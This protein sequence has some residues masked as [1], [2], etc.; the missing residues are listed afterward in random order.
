MSESSNE[1]IISVDN[2]HK[3]YIMGREA[4]E[5]L[6]GVS[7]DVDRGE[8]VCL[9]GPSG[10]GKTTLLNIL[11]GLDSPSRGHVIVDGENVVALN[12]E[13]LAR[14]R[15]RKMGFVFQAYNL[16]GNFT[17]EENVE[18]PMVLAG[19]KNGTRKKRAKELMQ[20]VGLADRAHH[21]PSELSG[22]QQ[23]RVAI[24]RA[25]ANDPAILVGDEMTGD[26]DSATGFEIM[27]LV[28]KLNKEHGTTVVYVTHDPR[29]SKYAHRVIQL[30][31]GKISAENGNGHDSPVLAVKPGD[32]V[33]DDDGKLIV[34]RGKH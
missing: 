26:L 34:D 33:I 4:V 17:A 28:E 15:L 32:L 22:G 3:S 10:S 16:L 12:E 18:A 23:Q 6:R 21:Y 2:I 25:M 5:A 1:P 8:I 9:M 13:A 11:G 7:L 24:A 30:R 29:M 14:M 27:S 20:L 19:V 31:D